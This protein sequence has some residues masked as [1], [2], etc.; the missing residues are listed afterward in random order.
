[1]QDWVTLDVGTS[2]SGIKNL[3]LSAT[4]RNIM[5]RKPSTDPLARPFNTAWYSPQGMNVSLGASYR[6]W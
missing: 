2:Y 3:T 6:F 4:V 5:D 1:V